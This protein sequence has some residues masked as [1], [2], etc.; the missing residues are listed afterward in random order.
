LRPVSF[1][2]GQTTGDHG[3]I[4]FKILSTKNRAR[5]KERQT[6]VPPAIALPPQ[7]VNPKDGAT[8]VATLRRNEHNS[9]N[10]SS[11]MDIAAHLRQLEEQ[12][13]HPSTRKDPATLSRLIADDFLEFG[14]SGRV[15]DKA[16]ILAALASEPP[17]SPVLLTH[18]AARPLA[19]DVVLVT[20]R[21]T[22][23]SPSGELIATAQ[24]GSIWVYRD[25]RWQITFHQG[26]PLP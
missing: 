4:A 11:F 8:L 25:S 1:N 2:Y 12:L 3:T 19:E 17:A 7:L 21:T 10:I 14:A 22:R 20:Y 13:L 15:Y 9:T 6:I 5:R 18:F 24:R 16:A 23:H 26:T